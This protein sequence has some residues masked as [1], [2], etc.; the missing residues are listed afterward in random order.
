ME[1][2]CVDLSVFLLP[3]LP[4]LRSLP[5]KPEVLDS[6]FFPHKKEFEFS[7]LISQHSTLTIMSQVSHYPVTSLVLLLQLSHLQSHLKMARRHSHKEASASLWARVSD[8]N[9]APLS[10]KPAASILW[11]TYLLACI[12]PGLTY[13]SHISLLWLLTGPAS[14]EHWRKGWPIADL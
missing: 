14:K 3:L 11:A 7:F 2:G 10:S 8:R 6:R 5:G 9:Q 4:W 1:K 13:L 12:L